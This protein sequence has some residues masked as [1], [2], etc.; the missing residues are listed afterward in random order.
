M[1]TRGK[2]VR[3]PCCN[4]QQVWL[5]QRGHDY[6]NV[7]IW[8][9]IKCFDCKATYSWKHDGV[10]VSWKVVEDIHPEHTKLVCWAML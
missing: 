3:L 9:G 6:D 2:P 4:H 10:R 5:V 7:L 8:T 1:K